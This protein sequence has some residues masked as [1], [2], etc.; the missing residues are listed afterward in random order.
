VSYVKNEWGGGFTANV[1][2]TNSGVSIA[3]A[4]AVG[5]MAS[6]LV[7]AAGYPLLALGGGI[8]TLAIVPSVIITARNRQTRP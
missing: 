3:I 5:G 6:G 7:A 2:V 1:T 4:G 8:L